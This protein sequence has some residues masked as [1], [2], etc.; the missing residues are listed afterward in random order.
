MKGTGV[1]KLT[2]D[3]MTGDKLV[4]LIED[5]GRMRREG[6][7]AQNQAKFNDYMKAIV[8]MIAKL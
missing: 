2:K 3:Y 1:L 4:N 6:R 8:K 7:Y 5:I